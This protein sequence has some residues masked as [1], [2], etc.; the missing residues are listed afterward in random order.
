MRHFSDYTP[1]M[2]LYTNGRGWILAVTLPCAFGAAI[3]AATAANIAPT[4]QDREAFET[5]VRQ[6]QAINFF[7]DPRGCGIVLL[8]ERC[9]VVFTAL[10]GDLG[11][12]DGLDSFVATGNSD[13]FDKKWADA[14]V[15]PFVDAPWKDATRE[16]WLRAAGAMY[17]AY[18]TPDW[19]DYAIMQIPVYRDLVHYAADVSPY[20]ALLTAS[21]LKAGPDGVDISGVVRIAQYFVPAAGT[22]FP[23]KAEPQLEIATGSIGDAQLGVYCSTAQE[24]FE[25]PVLFL[26]P[27]SRAFLTE[28]ATRLGDAKLGQRFVAVSGPDQWKAAISAYQVAEVAAM[29]SLPEKRRASFIFGM[30]AAQTAYN[31]AVLR[32]ADPEK[33][34]IAFLQHFAATVPARVSAKV[35]PLVAAGSDWHALNRAATDLTLEIMRPSGA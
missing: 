14:N 15:V 34:Q 18:Y 4:A 28:L 27:S 8:R 23:P 11:K 25:S 26:A 33:Q 20:D 7:S 30:M 19:Q 16:T 17:E 5:G 12:I 29:K 2:R 35:A 3:A 24:M 10:T 9:K 6:Q 1:L 31:A 13:L 22:V 32:E 21:D